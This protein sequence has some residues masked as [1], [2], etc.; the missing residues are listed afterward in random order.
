[1]PS[2]TNSAFA[3]F[4]KRILQINQSSNTGVDDTPRKIQDGSGVDTSISVAK[5][6]IHIQPENADITSTMLV[7]SLLGANIFAVDTINSKVKVGSSQ[8]EATTQFKEMGL[9]E[10]SPNAAG[11][12]YPLIANKVGMQGAEALTYDDD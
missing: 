1:M 2:F 10:F 5:N 11:Y 4:Y 12:H 7:R 9:Y 3:F 8:V 6:G